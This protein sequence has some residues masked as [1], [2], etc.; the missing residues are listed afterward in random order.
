MGKYCKRDFSLAVFLRH[1]KAAW[2]DFYFANIMKLWMLLLSFLSY[3]P[4]A[5][6][7]FQLN[8]PDLFSILKIIN[9]AIAFYHNLLMGKRGAVTG[10]RQRRGRKIRNANQIID[11]LMW[12][13]HTKDH[14]HKIQSKG[15][16][17]DRG[18]S[19]K[20]HFLTKSFEAPFFVLLWWC[21]LA[22]W[23]MIKVSYS[24]MLMKSNV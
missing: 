2:R 11:E 15:E 19:G 9:A 1:E 8:T 22:R 17:R 18:M 6:K 23:E 5:L 12:K 21:I 20:S 7:Y 3:H 14:H 24:I 13:T 4:K 10:G 16:K